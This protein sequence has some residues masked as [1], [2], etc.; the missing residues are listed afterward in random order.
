LKKAE[1]ISTGFKP[2]PHQKELKKKLRRFSAIAAHRR[3]GKSVFSVNHA[4]DEG[5]HCKFRNPQYGLISPLLSQSKR[6]FWEDLK[7]YTSAL[8]QVDINESELRVD[9]WR[10]NEDR[11]RIQLFGAENPHALKGF[12]MDGG[13]LDENQDMHPEFFGRTIRPMLSDRLGWALWIGT[14]KGTS[15][16]YELVQKFKQLMEQGNK[17]YFA[18]EYRASE[19]GIIPQK[20]LEDT[21]LTMSE[22][23]YAEEYELDPH[24]ANVGSYFGKIIIDLEKTGKIGNVPYDHALPVVTSWDLGIDDTTAIW[25]IQPFGPEYRVIDY[26]EASGSGLDFYAKKLK[27]KPYAY[28]EHFMPH[29]IKVRDLGSGISRYEI[30]RS[31]GIKPIRIAPKWGLEDGIEALRKV[32]PRCRFDGQKCKRL[33]EALKEYQRKWNPELMIFENRPLHNW[34]SHGV[35]AGRTF[36]VTY[37]EERTDRK[38]LPRE[39]ISEYDYFG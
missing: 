4:I 39:A 34:A 33:L 35:D 23:Q 27:E 14:Y 28:D 22:Q 12:Y 6:N 1:K 13:V 10:T 36:A 37:R 16:H 20:E 30:A 29:D 17:D 19:T 11:I 18:A 7:R 3:F 8:P 2:R 9:I 24:S 31:H 25:F 5:F 21:K 32:L 26:L 15:N 38:T